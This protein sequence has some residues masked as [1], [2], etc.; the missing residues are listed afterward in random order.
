MEVDIR[1]EGIYDGK[2]T[3]MPLM[4]T[5]FVES[6]DKIISVKCGANHSMAVSQ[7]G[8][9]YS[10]GEGDEG[11]LGQGYSHKT[12]QCHQS[13]YPAKVKGLP[14]VQTMVK[15]NNTVATLGCGKNMNVVV[16]N[17]GD[18]FFWGRGEYNKVSHD[19]REVYSVP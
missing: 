19:D 1:E 18:A 2:W 7:R 14:D 5:N 10:W 17:Q 11:K 3:G 12:R 16:L 13:D 15:E 6:C 9:C 8:I 4:L